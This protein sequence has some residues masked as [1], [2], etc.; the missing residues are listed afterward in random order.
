MDK[1]DILRFYGTDYKNMTMR[2]LE[3]AD[4]ASDIRNKAAARGCF[5]DA[6][7]KGRLR[8]GIKPNLVCPTPADFGG[9]THPE[10]VA[11][12]AEYLLESGFDADEIEILE[13]SWVGDKTAEAFEYCGYNS[14]A[15]GYGIRL[16]DMQLERDTVSCECSGMQLDI[17]RRALDTDYL[18]NV[19]VLKGHCQTKVTCALKN[20]KGLIPNTEK[21]RFHS[22][23]L[24]GPIAH[25]NTVLK[26]DLIVTDHICGD[27][28]F[29]EG[30][31]PLIRNC[32]MLSRDPVLT[33]TLACRIL[34]Y[35]PEDVEYIGIAESLGVGSTALDTARIRT[36]GG[37]PTEGEPSDDCFAHS[38]A[39]DDSFAAASGHR[40]IQAGYS[41]D[42]IDSCSACYG[43]LLPALDRLDREGLLDKLN[44]RLAGSRLC[45]G[46]G[47]R[48]KHGSYGVGA[49]TSGFDFCVRGCPPDEESIYEQLKGLI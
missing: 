35:K 5:S 17:C 23:G 20:M 14:L 41:V 44:D 30:G 18:I 7:T 47:Y 2:L 27:P 45:I 43:V 25:L 28:D 19:P 46:Q 39:G 38:E 6:K 12:I 8:I 10:I 16:T 15:A 31:N 37:S 42:E 36:I 22:M 32:I 34:G 1:S 48:G 33:D 13:G 24:H 29:E 3:E 26:P 49:C 21:R 9:T 40:L 11:G 4:I